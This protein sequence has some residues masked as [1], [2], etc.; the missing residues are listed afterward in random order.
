MPDVHGVDVERA[1]GT[2]SAA[3]DACLL[4]VH[5]SIATGRRAAHA[6][7]TYAALAGFVRVAP[8][9]GIAGWARWRAAVDVGL[10]AVL[11]AVVAC[12]ECAFLLRCAYLIIAV[13]QG[14]ACLP[15]GAWIARAP[16][17][18]RRFPE[19]SVKI[20]VHAPLW[21]T[22]SRLRASHGGQI[23]AMFIRQ[24]LDQVSPAVAASGALLGPPCLSRMMHADSLRARVDRTLVA[25]IEYVTV[26]RLGN[27]PPRRVAPE[28]HTIAGPLVLKLLRQGQPA[29]AGDAHGFAAPG[30]YGLGTVPGRL[31]ARRVALA[32]RPT[33]PLAEIPLF[34][35]GARLTAAHLL[36][37][38][39]PA[40]PVNALRS[41]SLG[42]A[43]R[44]RIAP[45]SLLDVDVGV[46][47]AGRPEHACQE[48]RE[49]GTHVPLPH[50]RHD[51]RRPRAG[52]KEIRSRCRKASADH[53]TST[54]LKFSTTGG[55]YRKTSRPRSEA[56]LCEVGRYQAR[57]SAAPG[58][59][60][61]AP[62]RTVASGASRN[63]AATAPPAARPAPMKAPT[64][65]AVNVLARPSA[66][67]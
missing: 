34:L 61:T 21:N 46:T 58:A 63:P 6:V 18:G 27:H 13:L 60:P 33:R 45:R 40:A 30:V 47:A 23:A 29:D 9:A 35:P 2:A 43:F 7:H 22:P 31:A 5:D 52:N 11:H 24:A 25:V 3:V 41:G 28:G 8:F 65:R 54:A 32:D 4:A 48:D 42:I 44:R 14:Q 49:G 66:S 17:V 36:G 50:A 20:P 38:R 16:A 56:R 67:A 55:C 39:T 12:G 53:I 37:L 64:D 62:T 10:N 19:G 51:T 59:V 15:R 1:C 57:E 26:I